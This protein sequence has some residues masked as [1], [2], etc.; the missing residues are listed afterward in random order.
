MSQT[1][2]GWIIPL[3]NSQLIL[4]THARLAYHWQFARK[5][6]AESPIPGY[7]VAVYGER[8]EAQYGHEVRERSRVFRLGEKDIDRNSC[9]PLSG[10]SC[11]LYLESEEDPAHPY[12]E[13]L[14]V[15]KS[16]LAANNCF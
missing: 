14:H 6:E 1:K 13:V 3:P 7:P 2:C 12:S 4:C 15:L 5:G 8:E 10:T 11:S 16:K 9:Q